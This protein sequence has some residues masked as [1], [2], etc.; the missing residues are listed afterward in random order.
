VIYC[1][2]F[3][4]PFLDWYCLLVED[5]MGERLN[6]RV[7]L[8]MGVG[9]LTLPAVAQITGC[10]GNDQSEPE[11]KIFPDPK[12][13]LLDLA[14]QHEFGAVVQ[15]SNHAGVIKALNSDPGG[16]IAKTLEEIIFQEVRH[17]IHLSDIL[18]KNGIEPT[19]AVWPPQTAAKPE[20]MVQQDLAAESGAIALYQQI[21]E[22]DFDNPTKRIIEKLLRSEKA[23]HHYFTKLLAELG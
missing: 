22:Q 12:F 19:V 13:E 2:G 21:L 10:R 18:K 23:H 11:K 15:Y 16:T 20:E 6:R 5:G 14:L 1:F 3:I 4:L 8:S 7:F 9:L 17:S